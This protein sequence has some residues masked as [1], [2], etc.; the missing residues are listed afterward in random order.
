[1]ANKSAYRPR[2]PG[3]TEEAVPFKYP[4]MPAPLV[5]QLQVSLMK[6]I[7]PFEKAFCSCY[8]V[9]TW[10]FAI[11]A[12]WSGVWAAWEI[13]LMPNYQDYGVQGWFFMSVFLFKEIMVHYAQLLPYALLVWFFIGG[14]KYHHPYNDSY[15]EK[16][17]LHVGRKTY[18]SLWIIGAIA[19]ATLIWLKVL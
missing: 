19:Y 15:R 11:V 16:A 5:R 18:V 9:F 6:L 2:I 7:V 10:A 12:L 8:L 1:M 14:Y 13:G 3:Y 4:N 17:A